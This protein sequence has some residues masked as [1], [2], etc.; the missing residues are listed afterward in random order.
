M[1]CSRVRAEAHDLCVWRWRASCGAAFRSWHGGHFRWRV[2]LTTALSC[3]LY[4]A[5]L[6]HAGQRCQGLQLLGTLWFAR[7]SEPLIARRVRV[8][9]ACEPAQL[10]GIARCSLRVASAADC[11]A[12]LSP[13][14]ASLCHVGQRCQGLQHCDWVLRVWFSRASG[15][16]RRTTCACAWRAS[17]DAAFRSWHGGHFGWRVLLT[18]ALSCRPYRASL[19]RVIQRCLGLQLLD[20][21]C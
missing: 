6:R 9:L 21:A 5:S 18:A 1:V 7:A 20:T 17:C 13:F 12:E 11:C 14:H 3:R 19:R 8:A 15:P 2:L 16:R 10:S 4:R